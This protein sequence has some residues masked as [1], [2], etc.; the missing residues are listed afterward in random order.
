MNVHSTERTVISLFTGAGGLDLGFEAAGFKNRLCVEIDGDARKTLMHNRPGWILAEPGNIYELKPNDILKQSRMRPKK[1]S[2]LTGGPPCQ[3]FSK[4][5]FWSSGD[6]PRLSDPRSKTLKA[7]LQT[8]ELI[9]PKV[10]LLEN[11]KGL[12]FNGKDEGLQF[13][14]R[15][16]KAINK[17]VG[18]NY[19]LQVIHLNAASYGVPQF[20]ERVFIL[21][22]ITGKTI[23]PPKSTHDDSNGLEPYRTAWD[24]I[25]DLDTSTWPSALNLTGRWANLLKSIPEG[26]NYLWHT[27]RNRQNGGE[28]LF[29]WRTRYWSFL[30]KLAKNQPSWTI[31]AMPGP[32]TGP[33]HWKNRLLSIE[34]LCRLQTFP[35]GYEIQG[36]RRS[37][38]CQIG[39]AVPSAI[40]E[41][42]GLEIRRQLFGEN[43]RK[44]L[45]LIPS[46]RNNCPRAVV[47]KPV[48]KS[49]LKFRGIYK[50][51]PGTGLGPGARKRTPQFVSAIR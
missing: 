3:P 41:L 25:G 22:S 15:G 8:V 20:R 11:V 4:A 14:I 44:N 27:S 12:A 34:E 23:D 49:Y 5:A 50:D 17:R 28:P 19:R 39:N 48:P 26:R 40:G 31:P 13:L 46:K 33:F 2:L 30:L 1:V 42:F 47:T 38:Q 21:A 43:V 36:D 32:A 6:S 7:F 18:C 51:H 24:A 35:V 45:T 29:G 37:A 16:I 9:L 10:L